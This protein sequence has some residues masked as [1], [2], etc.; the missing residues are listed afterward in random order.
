[1]L[2]LLSTVAKSQPKNIGLE[3]QFNFSFLT[4]P[5]KL[6]TPYKTPEG[7]SLT[8]T[9]IQF[10]MGNVQLKDAK[11]NE[12]SLTQKYYLVALAEDS[13][14]NT[15]TLGKISKKQTPAEIQFSIGID[16]VSNHSAKQTDALDPLYGMFWTWAQGYIFFKVEGYYNT[17]EGERGGFVYHIGGNE[18]YRTVQLPLDEPIV[19]HKKTHTYALEVKLER[20]F[21]LYDTPAVYLKIP[22]NNKKISVMGGPQAPLI[23]DN[24]MKTFQG[25]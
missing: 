18:C 20:L 17:K 15:I 16:S 2:L 5:F 22:E 4:Q 10:Y 9:K 23:A 13:H 11:N 3:L 24:F 12:I 14:Q 19:K 6:Q 7:H 8:F 1:M 21:G 25:F